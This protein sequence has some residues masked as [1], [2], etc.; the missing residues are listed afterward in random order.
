MLAC[1]VRINIWSERRSADLVDALMLALQGCSSCE[2][3]T[4][5]VIK[6]ASQSV[7]DEHLCCA[8]YVLPPSNEGLLRVLLNI[9]LSVSNSSRH[10]FVR[11]Y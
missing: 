7:L 10:R 9:M 2:C 11:D 1:A 3:L 8:A 6:V 4:P 5:F